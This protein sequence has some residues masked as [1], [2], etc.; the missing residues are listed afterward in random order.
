MD[1]VTMIMEKKMDTLMRENINAVP[2]VNTKVKIV[3]ELMKNTKIVMIPLMALK[4]EYRISLTK[5]SLK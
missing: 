1:M 4:K 2:L 3:S 5:N